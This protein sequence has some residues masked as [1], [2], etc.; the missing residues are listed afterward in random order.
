MRLIYT[1]EAGTGANEPVTVVVGLIV[2]VDSQW[3]PTVGRIF[4]ALKMV[5]EKLR[6]GFIFHATEVWSA[7]YKADWSME[8]RFAFLKRIMEIPRESGLAIAQGR[9]YR[10]GTINPDANL[11]ALN[12][13]PEQYQH[14]HAFEAC[15]ASADDYITTFAASNELAAI[16]AE[17]IPEMR[18]IL[19]EAT[20]QLRTG[21]LVIKSALVTN[22]LRGKLLSTQQRPVAMQIRRVIDDIHFAPKDSAMILWLADA[23]AY[24]LR[25]YYAE[26]PFG[27]D[28]ARAIIGPDAG[29]A[30][31]DRDCG[32]GY[33]CNET[34]P[35]RFSRC[36]DKRP[37]L[38]DK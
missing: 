15:M 6:G 13:R 11:P 17:D 32:S 33:M 18:R 28:F 7:K 38:R 1:D 21:R 12:M 22:L 3:V 5:P 16:V 24:G 29:P 26:Q 25:R 4:D 19:R 9:F 30:V 2:N 35:V 14:M 36:S 37:S 8:E 27:I 10:D 23:V 20:T 34:P 31:R